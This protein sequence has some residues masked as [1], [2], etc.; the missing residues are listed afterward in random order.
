M[1]T[2]SCKAKHCTLAESKTEVDHGLKAKNP[3][4]LPLPRPEEKRIELTGAIASCSVLLLLV[5]CAEATSEG[6]MIEQILSDKGCGAFAGLVAATAGVG[7]VFRFFVEKEVETP[8]VVHVFREKSAG[9][10]GLTI[11]CPDDEA[12]AAF[13]PRFKN[14]SADAQVALLL[15]HGLPAR[16]SEEALRLI[17][18]EALKYLCICKLNF[19]MHDA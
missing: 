13:V 15:Y 5:P 18:G 9:D 1:P 10:V 2:I 16:C 14:L 19:R 17:D 3:P 11:F 7:E 8:G 4:H 12:V 6:F